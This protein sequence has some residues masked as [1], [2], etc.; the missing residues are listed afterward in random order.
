MRGSGDEATAVPPLVELATAALVR[1]HH[2]YL[3]VSECVSMCSCICAGACRHP[4]SSR[5]R[6]RAQLPPSLPP[7]VR[8]AMLDMFRE[9]GELTL[10]T[11]C[12]FCAQDLECL[13]LAACSVSDEW[14]CAPDLRHL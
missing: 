14:C 7:E 11:L 2:S 12:K 6:A 13:D 1:C 3:Q 10:S 4:K 9:R 8:E 5:A